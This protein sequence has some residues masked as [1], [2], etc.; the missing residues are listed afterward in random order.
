M[1]ERQNMK[2]QRL[3]LLEGLKQAAGITV[4][5]DVFRAFTCE[6]FMYRY[7]AERI[8]IEADIDRCREISGDAILVGELNAVP[9]EGFDL[10]NSPFEIMRRGQS[11]FGG[12]EVIH[13]TTAGVTG[14]VEAMERADEVLLASFVTARATADYILGRNPEIVSIAAMGDRA[15]EK[16]PED[17]FCGDYIESLLTGKPYDH[18]KALETILADE[19]A[20][21]FLRA[22]TD[23]LPPED[24]LICL[25]CDLF[26]FTLKAER[27][28]D[29]I[30]VRKIETGS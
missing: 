15:V 10:G 18:V 23:Y 21:K 14:A 30:V 11:L 2:I 7:G 24:P 9:L 1:K 3:S 27:E 13:R 5:I 22:D 6:P 16:A 4:V 17:E 26:D 29:R 28:N 20:Q 8:C 19:T 25:Q 12:R